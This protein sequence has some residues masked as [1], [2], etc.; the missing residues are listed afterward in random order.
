MPSLAASRDSPDPR[1][2]RAVPPVQTCATC[3]NL[4]TTWQRFKRDALYR[5]RTVVRDGALVGY[6]NTYMTTHMKWSLTY[7]T[8]LFRRFQ[9][10]VET[11]R[12][13]AQS[14]ADRP[15]EGPV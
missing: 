1:R 6:Q 2:S 4:F 15:P 8:E 14:L 3:R 5:G 9:Y 7:A 10:H 11:C 13:V 12:T